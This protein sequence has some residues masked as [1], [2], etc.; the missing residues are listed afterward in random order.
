MHKVSGGCH[1]GNIVVHAELT[2]APSAYNPRACDCDFCRKHAAAYLSDAHGSLRIQIGNEREVGMY[3][4]GNAIA[5]CLVCRICGVLVGVCY[6]AEGHL[7]AAVNAKAIDGGTT[8]GAEQPVSPKQLSENEKT[9]RWKDIWFSN[10]RL[11]CGS[12]LT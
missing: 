11:A 4:Q 7:Y 12:R 6:R 10:V 5:E 3:R 1:C 9:A 2:R 8:F